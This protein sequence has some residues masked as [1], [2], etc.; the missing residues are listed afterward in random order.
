MSLRPQL[1]EA[2]REAAGA[3]SWKVRRVGLEGLSWAG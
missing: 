2:L 1:T 3:A